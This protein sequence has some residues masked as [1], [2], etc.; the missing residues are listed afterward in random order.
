MEFLKKV[1]KIESIFKVKGQKLD[2]TEYHDIN[3][4]IGYV[5]FIT[6]KGTFY[7]LRKVGAPVIM[8]HGDWAEKFLYL[9]HKRNTEALD[10]NYTYICDS[11]EF[12]F[13]LV[14]DDNDGNYQFAPGKLGF[15]DAQQNIIEQLA[16]S[17]G[18][19]LDEKQIYR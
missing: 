1:I 7:R 2:F 13:T 17:Q 18:K 6:P 8:T 5:G 10:V 16:L 4:M 14:F 3:D 12:N 9:H 19:E 11:E 15:T